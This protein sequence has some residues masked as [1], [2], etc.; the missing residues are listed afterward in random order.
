MERQ[1]FGIRLGA[2]LIDVVAIV[3]LSVIIALIFGQGFV[4]PYSN[5]AGM[6]VGVVLV[7]SLVVLAYWSTEIFRAASPGK[8]ALGLSIAGEN[9]SAATQN[10][11]VTRWAVKNAGNLIGLA[12]AVVGAVIPIFGFVLGI[13]SGLAALAVVV[14]CFL[15]LGV[16]RQAL[17]D[18]LAHTAVFRLQPAPGFPVSPIAPPAGYSQPMPPPPPPPSA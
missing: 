6:G 18:M 9:G 16:Q 4:F 5:R 14:G 10:Q 1:G 17:H 8:M 12:A 11:L 2:F 7:R 15:A 3:I 13:V